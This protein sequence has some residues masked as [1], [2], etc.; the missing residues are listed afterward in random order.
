MKFK[1]PLENLN[2]A[3]TKMTCVK[4]L[5]DYLEPKSSRGRNNLGLHWLMEFIQQGV[6]NIIKDWSIL[7]VSLNWVDLSAS[8]TLCESVIALHPEGA[9][10]DWD[11]LTVQ[12]IEENITM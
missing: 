8:H 12:T 3:S 5:R 11:L 7:T 10:L 1:L 2:A 4:K 6:R 9:L